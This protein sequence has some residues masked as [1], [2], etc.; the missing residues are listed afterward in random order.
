M[1]GFSVF[2]SGSFVFFSGFLV[3]FL[4]ASGTPEWVTAGNEGTG[5]GFFTTSVIVAF[6]LFVVSSAVCV[7]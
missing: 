7:N 1:F 6:W 5:E 2:S 3:S 4:A